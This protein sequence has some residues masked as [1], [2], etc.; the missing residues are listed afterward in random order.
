MC[1]RLEGNPIYATFFDVNSQM[2]SSPTCCIEGFGGGEGRGGSDCSLAGK[3]VYRLLYSLIAKVELPPLNG[4]LPCISTVNLQMVTHSIIVCKVKGCDV[5]TDMVHCVETLLWCVLQGC[6]ILPILY[7]PPSPPLS[8]LPIITSPHFISS[9]HY[10]LPSPDRPLSGRLVPHAVPPPHVMPQCNVPYSGGG[11]SLVD[12]D[13]DL[14]A[15]GVSHNLSTR[16]ERAEKIAQQVAAGDRGGRDI[17]G[18]GG[19]GDIGREEGG[20]DEKE[21]GGKEDMVE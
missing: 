6:T 2:R 21:R 11:G 13:I 15:A 14:F 16:L 3:P 10:L 7:S 19:G 5:C 4:Q 8:S 9:S 18:E 17:G 20:W 1:F 12:E